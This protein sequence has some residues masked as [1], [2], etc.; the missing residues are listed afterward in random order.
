[1]GEKAPWGMGS[2][3]GV[4]ADQARTDLPHGLFTQSSSHPILTTPWC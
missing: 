4:G 2:S 1:M 3:E